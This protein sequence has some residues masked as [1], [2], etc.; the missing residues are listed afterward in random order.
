[1]D[2]RERDGVDEA[3]AAVPTQSDL[4][5]V[6]QAAGSMRIPS[7]CGTVGAFEGNNRHQET[8]VD[9]GEPGLRAPTA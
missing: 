8:A 6:R 5:H 7:R 1:M 4:F 2:G 9:G 3:Y